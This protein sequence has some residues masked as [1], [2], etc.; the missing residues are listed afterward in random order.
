MPARKK[1]TTQANDPH[2]AP[3][4]APSPQPAPPAATPAAPIWPALTAAPG[5]TAAQI[6][7]AAGTSRAIT[8]RELAALETSGHATRTPG[9]RTGRPP[10]PGT[11]HGPHPAPPHLAA[12]PPRAGRHRSGRDGGHPRHEPRPGRRR[13]P[14]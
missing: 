7:T 9:A 1:N 3:H 13:A 11:R 5:A 8:S 4:T 12:R 6:A 14:P 2:S 10:A